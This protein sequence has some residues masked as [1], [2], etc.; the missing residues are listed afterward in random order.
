MI[1]S[2]FNPQAL[3]PMKASGIW[4]FIPSTGR[5]YGLEQNAWYDGRRDVLKATHAALDYLQTLHRMFGDWELALAAYNCGEGCVARALGRGHGKAYASLRLP[6][7][8][9]NY[10]PKLV[11]V[12]NVIRDPERFGVSLQAIADEAYFMQVTLDRP[13]TAQKAAKLAEM[14]VDEFIALN[15]AFQRRVI[16]ADSQ[17][18]LLLPVDRVEAFQFNASR[19]AE[20]KRLQTYQARRGESVGS[21]AQRFGVSLDWMKE[22]N[23]IKLHGGK[24]ASAQ[25]LVVPSAGKPESRVASAESIPA[26]AQQTRT[27]AKPAMRTHTVR[28][29]DTLSRVAKRYNVK[30]A[31]IRR[32]NENAEPL[33]PGSTLE[34]PAQPS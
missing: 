2:A 15:P 28:K 27:P 6:N 14:N 24:L 21:I 16:Y 31:D 8:T 4:Q 33:M 13:M 10:V 17:S 26:R 18:T 3:S 30:V 32:W 22:H 23:P 12:R 25:T 1:E 34:I 7:E 29:G 9:R 5:I 20:D 11:A 19:Q